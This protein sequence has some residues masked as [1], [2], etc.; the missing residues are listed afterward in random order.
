MEG[1]ERCG[2]QQSGGTLGGPGCAALRIAAAGSFANSHVTNAPLRLAELPTLEL[3]PLLPPRLVRFARC[4]FPAVVAQFEEQA[5]LPD[6]DDQTDHRQWTQ[7]HL[8]AA[9]LRISSMAP[10]PPQG[11]IDADCMDVNVR[12][13]GKVNSFHFCAARQLI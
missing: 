9:D 3:S 10:T 6:T 4:S 1:A 8:D 13:P 12:G 2:K 7:Q 5:M 11:E